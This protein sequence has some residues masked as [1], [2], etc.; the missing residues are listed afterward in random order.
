MVVDYWEISFSNIVSE[1]FR[2]TANIDVLPKW[3]S[4]LNVYIGSLLTALVTVI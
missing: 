1:D 4:Y 3:N 2:I